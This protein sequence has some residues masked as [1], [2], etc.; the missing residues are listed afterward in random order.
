MLDIDGTITP[1]DP[2]GR[3]TKKVVEAITKAKERAAVCIVTGRPM[4]WAMPI[5][6]SLSLTSPCIVIGGAQIINPVTKKILWQ[7]MIPQKEAEEIVLLL[8]ELKLPFVWPK[9]TH[10]RKV[11]PRYYVKIPTEGIIELGVPNLSDENIK[12][13]TERLEKFKNIAMHRTFGYRNDK[14]WLQI[15]H[16]EATKQHAIHYVA[17]MLRIDTHEIIGVGD[18]YNDFPLLMACGLKVAMGNAVP[19]L[20]KI[21]DYIAPSVEDD[22]VADVIEKFIL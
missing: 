13:V 16:A 22:G 12:T 2:H 18:G 3:P 6:K 20:K 21:A 8:R 5:I 10:K 7:K 14:D 17:K 1:Q 11:V 15:T 9:K 19:E 4:F